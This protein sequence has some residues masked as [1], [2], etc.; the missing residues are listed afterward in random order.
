MGRVPGCA[1]L[2]AVCVLA[3]CVP[4][5]P[6]PD[7]GDAADA[8]GSSNEVADGGRPVPEETCGES[9]GHHTV[10]YQ[11]PPPASCTHYLGSIHVP[12]AV[13]DER[14]AGYQNLRAI[15]GRLTIFRG[16]LV[17]LESFRSLETIGGELS[18]RL[19]EE[20]AAPTGLGSLRDIGELELEYNAA[21][22]SLAGL[23]GLEHIRGD[24]TIRGNARLTRAE[25]DRVLA[26][27]PVDGTITIEDSL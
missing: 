20:L 16:R 26:D 1:P 12:D 5:D 18:I 4:V 9:G 3:A 11:P 22:T 13:D 14:L 17:D 8:S 25:I 23:E 27:V 10:P 24:V 21:L 19:T 7:A 2:V 6:I 15:D